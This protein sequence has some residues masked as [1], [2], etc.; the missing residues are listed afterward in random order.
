[1]SIISF[2]MAYRIKKALQPDRSSL[3]RAQKLIQYFGKM[4]VYL[5]MG[6]L[7]ETILLFTINTVSKIHLFVFSIFMRIVCINRTHSHH[8]KLEPSSILFPSPNSG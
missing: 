4:N 1:L 6:L 3:T 7:F 5:G 8:C 2:I